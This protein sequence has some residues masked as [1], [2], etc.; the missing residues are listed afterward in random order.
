MI[1]MKNLKTIGTTF[2][3]IAAMTLSVSAC[4]SDQKSSSTTDAGAD[5]TEA[6]TTAAETTT[7]ATTTTAAITTTA[8]GNTTEPETTGDSN[9]GYDA[10]ELHRGYWDY[11]L[12]EVSGFFEEDGTTLVSASAN[13]MAIVQNAT[14]QY[15]TISATL[16]SKEGSEANDNG[17]VFGVDN[18]G[19]SNYFWESTRCY[20]FLFVADGNYLYLAKVQYNG[21]TWTV[22]KTSDVLDG[23]THGDTF[24]ISATIVDTGK[25][26]VDIICSYNGEEIFTYTDS[27]PFTGTAFG[28]RAEVADVVYRDLTITPTT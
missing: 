16:T 24:T 3:L 8:D 20:Y 15:G 19:D 27:A 9:Y 22:C 7:A 10:E 18:E 5:T 2:L 21:N 17:I 23:Y 26:S 1:F 6:V 14:L 12:A 4:S 25:G 28:I 13:N 11:D